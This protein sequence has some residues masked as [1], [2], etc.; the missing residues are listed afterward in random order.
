MEQELPD[1][2]M[3]SEEMMAPKIIWLIANAN[4]KRGRSKKISI[5]VLLIIQ[6]LLTR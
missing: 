5:F 4:E 1:I 3:V 6:W 2:Q